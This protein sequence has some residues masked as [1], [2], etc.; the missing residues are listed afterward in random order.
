LRRQKSAFSFFYVSDLLG[1]SRAFA[2]NAIIITSRA[3]CVISLTPAD[4]VSAR[5]HDTD[6][7]GK[8]LV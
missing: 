3:E 8:Y 5:G 4:C 6:R 1:V 7:R 2:F